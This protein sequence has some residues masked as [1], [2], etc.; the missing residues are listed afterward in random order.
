MW[1]RVKIPVTVL[2]LFAG[3][4]YAVHKMAQSRE[5]LE[6]R[7]A[8]FWETLVQV[9]LSY[10]IVAAALIFCSYFF[11]SLRWREFLA[12]LK[13]GNLGNIF[14]STLIGFSA[15]ALL[16]RP[17]E[18]VRPLLIARKE[19]VA[20]SSQLGI[21]TLERI[22]DSLTVGIMIGAALLLFPL[23]NGL[24]AG[25]VRMMAHLKT[26]G[27]ILF[28]SALVLGTF[29]VVLRNNTSVPINVLLRFARALPER[30]RSGFQKMLRRV[31]ENFTA[32]LASIESISSLV[33]CSVFSVLVWI[34][35]ILTY[36]TVT[37]AFG[38]PLSSLGLGGVVLLMAASITGSLA[39]LPAVGGG[40]QL[41]TVLVLTKLFGIPLEIAS[42]AAIL[43]WVL[44]FMIVLIPGLPLAAR[45]GLSWQRLRYMVKTGV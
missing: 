21:W 27:I 31:L 6:F 35:V 22:F 26:G 23:E 10:L 39:Q 34:P 28:A 11:R 8:R 5:W 17:G 16:G 43:L 14:V 3:V 29:L 25:G 37:R 4:A 45:E 30:Y 36:W 1:Q 18:L 15:V 12:P 42:T 2:V 33:V 40:T 20:L 44:G 32:T 7:S 41:A 9:R 24:G 19:G 13:A 38:W